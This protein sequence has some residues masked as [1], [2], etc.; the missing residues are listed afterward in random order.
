MSTFV[1]TAIGTSDTVV[2]TG[3][4]MNFPQQG[5]IQIGSEQISYSG[6]TPNQFLNLTRGYNSTTPA[7]HL[8]NA[9]ITFI[10]PIEPPGTLNPDTAVATDSNSD[11]VSS[12]TTDTELGYVHG[13]TSAIQAQID[14]KQTASANNYVTP[15]KISNTATDD[16]TFPRDIITGRNIQCSGLLYPVSDSGNRLNMNHPGLQL[17]MTTAGDTAIQ[18]DM[19]NAT[20]ATILNMNDH[21]GSSIWRFLTDGRFQVTGMSNTQRDALAGHNEGDLI[22]STTD[23]AFEYWNGSVWKQIATV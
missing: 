21:N 3:G 20:L 15:A 7:A 6:I 19:T 12:N 17:I 22:Y 5:V 13:V 14:S 4:L 9:L 11:L 8:A 2:T 23:H 1:L 10:S 18:I 16:F